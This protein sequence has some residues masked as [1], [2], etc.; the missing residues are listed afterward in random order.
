MISFKYLISRLK[1]VK[2]KDIV[3]VFPMIAAGAAS[4][5][6]KRK[7]ENTWLICEEPGEAR[8]NGYNFFGYMRKE[9]PEIQTVYAI[10]KK[11]V[12]YLK[13]SKVGKCVEYGSIKHWLIYF[14]C[15]YNISSQ[16]GGKPNAALCSFMELN[17][18]F[19]TKNIFLQ[20]GI[21]IN[22]VR[23]L[24]RDR[25][26]IDLFITSTLPEYEYIKKNF[27]YPSETVVLT[28][29]PRFDSL[30]NIEVNKKKIVIMPTWRY[31]F[32]LKSKRNAN[33]D[34]KIENSEYLNC[35]LELLSSSD[36]KDII[37]KYKLEVIFYP[38]RNM[39]QYIEVFDKVGQYITV[40]DWRKFDIQELLK[41]SA[42][43]VTDYSSV[44]LDMV[45]MKKPVIFYQ[46]DE[47]KY[48]KYQYDEG[49]FDYHNTSFGNSYKKYLD[50][51][52]K[53]EEYAKR[54]FEVDQ[55]FIDEHKATFK[56]WD[57]NN[58]RRV[59]EAIQNMERK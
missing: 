28:G 7:Y 15:K 56:Y 36:L 8:D 41:S 51:C 49:Y 21:T 50:V 30:H 38:H 27:G 39:Q 35:W 13:V 43:L 5:F 44:F 59:Y 14:T 53:I 20:H 26:K 1:D 24:Y 55:N 57:I 4:V 18:I 45:Y 46:F 33:V 6:F 16:K 42:M 37:N 10:R 17:G 58:S 19:K 54:N 32:N 34:S 47:E 2:I 52:N 25:S 22:N 11:S 48:R 29:M 3:S 12:D 23:W 31:W 40:A 9:H